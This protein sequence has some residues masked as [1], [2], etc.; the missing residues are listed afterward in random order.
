MEQ[1]DAIRSLWETDSFDE[2]I[3]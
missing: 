1:N 2:V 3:D